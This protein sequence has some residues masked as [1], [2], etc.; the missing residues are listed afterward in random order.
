[1]TDVLSADWVLP[2]EA[3]PIRN[4]AVRKLTLLWL[5]APTITFSST[6]RRG[7]RA[8]FWKVRA[9]PSRAMPWAWTR[10]RSRPSNVTV[11]LCG[12]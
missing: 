7:K 1:M 9:T 2:V 12:W 4:G 3:P 11:P 8:R 5:W 6:V 10:S